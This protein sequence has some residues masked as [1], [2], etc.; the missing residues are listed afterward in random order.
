MYELGDLIQM[1]DWVSFRQLIYCV[2]G[3]NAQWDAAQFIQTL[4]FSIGMMALSRLGL[5]YNLF[6]FF[7]KKMI[8]I[9]KVRSKLGGNNS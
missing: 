7:K 1:A 4:A 3:K 8:Y 2:G 6:F 9:G 5:N